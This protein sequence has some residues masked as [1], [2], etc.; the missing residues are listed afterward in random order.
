MNINVIL[1]KA[2]KDTDRL[3]T[4]RVP[5]NFEAMVQVGS[6]VIVP[7][8]R[9]SRPMEAVVIEKGVAADFE[10]KE[11]LRGFDEGYDLSPEMVELLQRAG[12]YYLSSL[13]KLIKSAIPL[14]SKLELLPEIL[15]KDDE[16]RR[17]YE[18]GEQSLASLLKQ[19]LAIQRVTYQKK[20]REKTLKMVR[21]LASLDQLQAALLEL[22]SN[23]HRK[24]ALLELFVKDPKRVIPLKQA[25]LSREALRPLC[26]E[27]LM[28]VFDKTVYR[29]S[30]YRD[31]DLS[32]KPKPVL[33][34]EQ[35]AA[36]EQI[37]A[38]MAA[39]AYALFLLHGVTGS[40]KTEVYLQ[41]AEVALERNESVIVMVPEISLIPQMARVFIER[42]GPVVGFYHSQMSQEEKMEE[43][44]RIKEGEFRIVIG[45]RSAVFSP[46]KNLGLIV[47]DEEHSSSYKSESE[48]RYHGIQLAQM[49]AGQHQIPLVLGSATPRVETYC[50]ALKARGGIL[51]L[52]KRVAQRPMPAASLVDMREETMTAKVSLVSAR[53]REQ[54]QLRLEKGEQTILF[55]NKRGYASFVSCLQCGHVMSCPHC[56]VPLIYHK[57]TSHGECRLCGYRTRVPRQCPECGSPHYQYFGMGTEKIEEK[58]KGLFPE[59]RIIR[60]DSTSMAGK[61]ALKEAYEAIEA[62]EVD[63]ILGT[64][65]VAKGHDF[66]GV[67]LVGVLAADINLNVP[68]YTASEVT[69]ALITQAMGRSGRGE[70]P[71]EVIIQ[72]YNPEHYAIQSALASDYRVFYDFEIA[73]REA[74]TYPPFTRLIHLTVNSSIETMAHDYAKG[75]AWALREQFKGLDA[76]VV[77][78]GAALNLK[79]NHTYRYQVLIKG[80]TVDQP[81]IKG[82]INDII[83]KVKHPKIHVSV[84]VDPISLL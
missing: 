4:Y 5:E 10:V 15:F 64:Q 6:R 30:L 38:A 37:R 72:T 69:Y 76:R 58:I 62:R 9:G 24:R 79:V 11:I 66:K 63:I 59:A 25:G 7:F 71:G 51:T 34:R 75:L 78:P 74:M 47:V 48:P 67:T 61:Y 31:Q 65:I 84:D 70:V 77:G 3:Y 17:A 14:G 43:W 27:N 42:F 13:S 28:E 23:A 57:K 35:L 39:N 41:L 1:L 12:D 26:E 46:V 19:G 16:A 60:M 55:L 81:R 21:C 50:E 82:I 68:D 40:G 32:I 44:L 33:N 53:L 36:F 56:E 45:P 20:A 22:R 18:S 2:V 80:E 8:G 29:S 52:T 49:R 54:I 83:H 73:V